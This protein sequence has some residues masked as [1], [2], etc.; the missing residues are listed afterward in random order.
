MTVDFKR[1]RRLEESELQGLTFITWLKD[2]SF[3]ML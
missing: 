3:Q 1:S 2:W